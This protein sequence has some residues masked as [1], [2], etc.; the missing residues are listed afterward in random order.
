[1]SGIR[2][3]SAGDGAGLPMKR[4]AA[5]DGIAA[6]YL[7][8]NDRA[9]ASSAA[10]SAGAG[11]GRGAE[12]HAGKRARMA[13]DMSLSEINDAI[14]E[15]VDRKSSKAALKCL[16]MLAGLADPT[17]GV[18]VRSAEVD[19]TLVDTLC[20]ALRDDRLAVARH[21]AA[22]FARLATLLPVTMAEKF[23]TTASPVAAALW[24][25]IADAEVA[26]ST[27]K[28]ISRMLWLHHRHSTVACAE[29][30]EMK[31]FITCRVHELLICALQTHAGDVPIA[32]IV[33][34]FLRA[35][36]ETDWEINQQCLFEAGAG[37]ALLSALRHCGSDEA[38]ARE[39][40]GA[41]SRICEAPSEYPHYIRALVDAGAGPAVVAVAG[42]HAE[43]PEI[44]FLACDV[45]TKLAT[46][47]AA[48]GQLAAAGVPQM[49]ADVLRRWPFNG[50]TLETDKHAQARVFAVAALWRLARLSDA[51]CLTHFICAVP[52]LTAT[53]R[54]A[55]EDSERIHDFEQEAKDLSTS[56]AAFLILAR[57]SAAAGGAAIPALEAAHTVA[58]VLMAPDIWSAVKSGQSSKNLVVLQ[59]AKLQLLC[60]LSASSRRS[61]VV[62][63]V[64]CL[65]FAARCLSDIVGGLPEQ[66]PLESVFGLRS[67]VLDAAAKEAAR[68]ACKLITRV[69]R[70]V[71]FAAFMGDPADD[72]L[73][74]RHADQS[75][76]AVTVALFAAVQLTCRTGAGICCCVDLIDGIKALV[77]SK[78]KPSALAHSPAATLRSCG[79]AALKGSSDGDLDLL[80]LLGSTLASCVV[81][82]NA[83]DCLRLRLYGASSA[84]VTALDACVDSRS[85]T[86]L[87]LLQGLSRLAVGTVTWPDHTLQEAAEAAVTAVGWHQG[88]AAVCKAACELLGHLALSRSGCSAGALVDGTA[89]EL[90]MSVAGKHG[91]SDAIIAAT[92]YGALS[93]L[94]IAQ[95]AAHSEAEALG[96]VS[97][98]SIRAAAVTAAM[99][100]TDASVISSCSLLLAVLHL[101]SLSNGVSAGSSS[102]AGAGAGLTAAAHTLAARPNVPPMAC[103]SALPRADFS[104]LRVATALWAS[105]RGDAATIRCLPVAAAGLPAE[106]WVLAARL[107]AEAGHVEA[108]DAALEHVRRERPRHAVAASASLAIAV[109]RGH[110]ALAEKLTSSTLHRPFEAGSEADAGAAFWLAAE[111]RNAAAV[112]NLV[113]CPALTTQLSCSFTLIRDQAADL[114]LLER[115]LTKAA[116]HRNNVRAPD[117]YARA[118]DMA[119]AGGAGGGT[120]TRY[121]WH[122]DYSALG[123]EEHQARSSYIV[124]ALL[125][126]VHRNE[127]V[128][129]A[130]GE[131]HLAAITEGERPTYGFQLDT[132]VEALLADPRVDPVPAFAARASRDPLPT[133][134]PAS[135]WWPIMSRPSALRAT[136]F[137][138]Q[139]AAGD[140]L[141]DHEEY[142][143]A[144]EELQRIAWSRRRAA[145]LAW[146]R[147]GL[148]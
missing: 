117:S 148:D 48:A 102:G 141:V 87:V 45:I 46:D 103:L 42:E 54:E 89:A 123:N 96:G 145:V 75:L 39:A 4:R 60:R 144:A 38:V 142:E 65:R 9:D 118:S 81:A 136:V 11:T 137:K 17:A 93:L 113:R 84:L 64:D 130:A 74:L 47:S 76:D 62:F 115:L 2:A 18:T 86:T 135:A 94:L 99:R 23:Q 114:H 57:I 132:I 77:S 40:M 5:E 80:L 92:A 53:L 6:G 58:A 55:P 14:H 131:R 33:T 34:C 88:D 134:A 98:E 20:I 104:Q 72:V 49:V 139:G 143:L 85:D 59:N 16:E 100:H 121:A 90:L 140:G 15:K 41:L 71:E 120:A 122:D 56:G 129:A 97:F 109:A 29:S 3:G 138:R 25:H 52:Q 108:L 43:D 28:A 44:A 82:A 51:I 101:H 133:F 27:C 19:R 37:A 10:A 1:M 7:A 26:R 112:A 79:P 30:D 78:A 24:I 31:A 111:H 95:A 50:G 69:C 146:A 63:G 126:D 107:A 67:F 83:S 125:L 35:A 66:R 12:I 73:S 127:V 147:A 22:A 32:R 13:D 8:S 110:F 36:E 91:A 70:Y 124:Q 21:G 116:P 106:H 61:S 119:G 128:A 68:T 105:A